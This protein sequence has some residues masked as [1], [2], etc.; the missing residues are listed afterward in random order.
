MRLKST[1]FRQ[2]LHEA[3]ADS[4]MKFLLELQGEKNITNIQSKV[5]TIIIKQTMNNK[6]LTLILAISF[7][8]TAGK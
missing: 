4:I 1:D 5:M 2:L 6:P 7:V 8:T 3:C